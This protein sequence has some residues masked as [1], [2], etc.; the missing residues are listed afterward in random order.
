V[1]NCNAKPDTRL[2]ISMEAK[3]KHLR[4]RLTERQVMRLAEVLLEKQKN[5]SVIVRDALD[6]Y[7]DETEKSHNSQAQGHIKNKKILK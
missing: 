5:K 1:T 2:F 3:N 6:N 7:M 4:I